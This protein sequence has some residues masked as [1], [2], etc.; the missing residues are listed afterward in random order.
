M[1]RVIQP[2][3]LTAEQRNELKSRLAAL[4]GQHVDVLGYIYDPE[5]SLFAKELYT[6][7]DEAELA[8]TL[9][10]V[11]IDKGNRIVFGVLVETK[12]ESGAAASTLVSS[13]RL[14]GIR[15]VD[16]PV[17][18]EGLPQQFEGDLTAPVRITVGVNAERWAAKRVKDTQSD[19]PNR[20]AGARKE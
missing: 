4:R 10:A 12:S 5:S 7:L 19:A 6:V 9:S 13:F 16:P 1:E 17:P 8:V 2:R 3:Q 18:L 20:R 11:M 14:V 15:T